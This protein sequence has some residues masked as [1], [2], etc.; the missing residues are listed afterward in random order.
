MVRQLRKGITTRLEIDLSVLRDNFYALERYAKPA[1]VI[2]VLKGDAYGHGAVMVAKALQE[3][4]CS[5]CAVATLD[6]AL[7]LKRN[8]ITLDIH[9]L[10]AIS[11]EQMEI[12]MEEELIPFIAYPEALSVAE[13]TAARLGKRRRVHVK[14]DSGMGRFGLMLSDIPR[15]TEIM[16]N[17]KWVT[18]EGIATHLARATDDP[19]FSGKQLE[20]FE[21]AARAVERAA[22]HHLIRHALATMGV[23]LYRDLVAHDFVRVGSLLYGFAH[24]PIPPEVGV[25]TALSLKTELVQVKD[26]PKGWNLG[27]G[28]F[29]ADRDMKTGLIPVGIVDGFMRASAFK[30]HVLVRGSRCKVYGISAD[31]AIID[32]SSVPDARPGD[33][34]VVVGS[35]GSE[36]ISAYELGV[37]SGTNY[38][39]ILMKVM[40]R[41]PRIFTERGVEVEEKSMV[42]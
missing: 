36:V 20:I 39:E 41:V 31:S 33:E 2:A 23:L 18:I 30:A 5:R 3:T 7:L 17:V 40:T 35:Q 15:L 10:G 6:E 1:G 11:S 42:I 4:N 13:A 14:I 32:L 22:G 8:G 26:I 38:A 25:R 34:A 27:Y 21:E 9:L 24:T 37:A 16:S 19:E 28:N 29:I 12:A